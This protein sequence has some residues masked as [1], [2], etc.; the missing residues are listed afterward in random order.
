MLYCMASSASL[1]R[2]RAAPSVCVKMAAALPRLGATP[3]P[4]TKRPKWDDSGDN[5]DGDATAGWPDDGHAPGTHFG[6]RLTA[7]DR[8]F[9]ETFAVQRA[10]IQDGVARG[11]AARAGGAAAGGGQREIMRIGPFRLIRSRAPLQW[12]CVELRRRVGGVSF[13]QCSVVLLAIYSF[14]LWRRVKG[15]GGSSLPGLPWIP[16]RQSRQQ[17]GREGGERERERGGSRSSGGWEK[18]LRGKLWP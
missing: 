15:A 13:V 16:Y 2:R 11:R 3:P 10:P 8:R 14:V 6:E 4:P 9:C 1:W 17:T 18:T 5:G 12:D 7:K